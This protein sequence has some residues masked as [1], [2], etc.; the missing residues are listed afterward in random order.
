MCIY[1]C[2]SFIEPNG[3][4]GLT[5]TSVHADVKAAESTPE[6]HSF[7]AETRR[8]L[9]IMTNALYTDRH[10]F[11]RELVSNASD[12]LEKVRHM[13]VAGDDVAENDAELGIK[14]FTNESEGTLTI[15]DTGV[16]LTKDELKQN[17][18]TIAFSGSKAFLQE[19]QS[20]GQGSDTASNIIGQ[21][22]VGF[23]SAFMVADKVQ[24]FTKSAKP[25]EEG[26][27][28]TSAGD[29]TYTI[30]P[31]PEAER[32]SR[33]VLHLKDTAKEFA[34]AK[35]VQDVIEKYSNFVAFPIKLNDEVVS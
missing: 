8:V 27:C 1:Y 15:Q 31:A 14:V 26:W 32:G 17:L 21:F 2:T 7:Q 16:G 28:W 25:G 24:V 9:D 34:S 4:H 29:G 18:G 13:Q 3:I 22:G 33:I 30:E 6:T 12:A 19:M 5:S 35:T 23:Y 10:I 11:V 20:Q